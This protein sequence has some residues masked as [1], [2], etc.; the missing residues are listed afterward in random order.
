MLKFRLLLVYNGGCLGDF[1]HVVVYVETSSFLLCLTMLSL[2]NTMRY[3]KK[4]LVS[5]AIYR[6]T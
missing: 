5:S 4:T 6:Y 2:D 3:R 1:K